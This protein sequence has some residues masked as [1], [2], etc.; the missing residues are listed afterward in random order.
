M[1]TLLLGIGLVIQSS[2]D[3]V[4]LNTSAAVL[5]DNL[6]ASVG[7][8][9]DYAMIGVP[10]DDTDNGRDTGSLQVFF[11]SETGWVQHQKLLASDA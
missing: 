5:H 11:R 3:R 10:E 7:I 2:A 8:S 9:G 1:L 6:G 4:Q